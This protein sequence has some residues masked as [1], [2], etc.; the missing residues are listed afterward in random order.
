MSRSPRYVNAKVNGGVLRCYFRGPH[1]KGTIQGARLVRTGVVECSARWWDTYWSLRHGKPLPVEDGAEPIVEKGGLVPGSWDSLIAHYKAHN[2]GWKAMG[3]KTQNG[4]L[5]YQNHISRV[6]GSHGVAITDFDDVQALIDAKRTDKN[7]AAVQLHRVFGLLF[8]HA[9]LSLKWVGV[10]PVRDIKKPKS[11]N[12]DGHHTWTL[13]EV[14]G[15]REAFPILN[16]DGSPCMARRFLEMEIAWGSRASDL[17]QLGWKNV[18]SGV[19]S[20]AP[21]KTRISTG[22]VVHLD[23]T[24]QNGNNGEHLAA[25]LAHCPKSETFFLQ[26]PPAGFNQHTKGKVVALN[27][28]PWSYTRLEKTVRQWRA[29]AGVSDECTAHG[30]RKTF[31]TMM[32]DRDVPLLSLASALGDTPESA[33]IYIKKRDERRASLQASRKA[34]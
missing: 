28:E 26:K 2:T 27:P 7:G 6:I 5:I 4:Y 16:A 23:A 3:E 29:T 13:D 22:K 14:T 11:K 21:T 25:V 19:V 33:M 1:G 8:E 17:L 15:W 10:N 34:A 24:D 9:R 32:A 18:D 30:L 12:K 20:F 31:A